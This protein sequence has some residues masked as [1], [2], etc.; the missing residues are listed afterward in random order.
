MSG[1]R[2]TQFGNRKSGQRAGRTFADPW[3]S[4][5]SP[6]MFK[7]GKE[8]HKKKSNQLQPFSSYFFISVGGRL[9]IPGPS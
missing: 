7:I 1:K 2:V 8:F 9:F 3:L 4:E 6:G 5:D